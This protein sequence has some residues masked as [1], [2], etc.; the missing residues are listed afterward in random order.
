[1]LF[2]S[3]TF[4]SLHHFSVSNHEGFAIR[5]KP[6]MMGPL[7]SQFLTLLKSGPNSSLCS[8]ESE[9]RHAYVFHCTLIPRRETAVSSETL[10]T[11]PTFTQCKHHQTGSEANV[12]SRSHT[13]SLAISFTL[14]IMVFCVPHSTL[15]SV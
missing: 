7:K 9:W 10:A 4:Q 5:A 15:S 14:K 8:S 3:C 6:K 11:Q 12:K 1:V 2:W 13:H